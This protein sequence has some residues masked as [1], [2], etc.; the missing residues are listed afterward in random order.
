[1][2]PWGSETGTLNLTTPNDSAGKVS[3]PAV[4]GVQTPAGLPHPTLWW[5]SILRV[6]LTELPFPGAGGG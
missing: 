3:A 4:A 5:G 2:A 1:M 6:G